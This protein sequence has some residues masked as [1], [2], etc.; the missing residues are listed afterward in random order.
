MQLGL[1]VFQGNFGPQLLLF[2]FGLFVRFAA[3]VGLVGQIG[4]VLLHRR[5][6]IIPASVRGVG[7]RQDALLGELLDTPHAHPEQVRHNLHTVES[8]G[9]RLSIFNVSHAVT[10]FRKVSCNEG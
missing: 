10:S 1:T 3:P 9:K 4:R 5:H 7:G 6:K 8:T 2:E